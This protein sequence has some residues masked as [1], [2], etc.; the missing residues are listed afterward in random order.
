MVKQTTSSIP[1]LCGILFLIS[2]CPHSW[3]KDFVPHNNNTVSDNR[4]GLT[5]QAIDDNTVRNWQEAERYCQELKFAGYDDWRLPNYY[6]LNSLRQATETYPTID[7]K[8]FPK[9]KSAKYWTSTELPYYKEMA[10]FVDFGNDSALKDKNLWQKA[11]G[12]ESLY[13]VRC[14]RGERKRPQREDKKK[15]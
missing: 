3:A 2:P 12:M 14:S 15:R 11:M 1:L 4:T 5:W 6:E 10:Y 7:Q 9:T 8:L 13:Y